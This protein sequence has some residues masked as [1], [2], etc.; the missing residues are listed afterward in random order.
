MKNIITLV[1]F[2]LFFT[3]TLTAQQLVPQ[4]CATCAYGYQKL[5]T[6]HLVGADRNYYGS[7]RTSTT[8]GFSAT[9]Q[10]NDATLLL[11][12]VFPAIGTKGNGLF[13]N[14]SPNGVAHLTEL[15]GNTEVFL[16]DGKV[17]AVICGNLLEDAT[18]ASTNSN[19]S[20]TQPSPAVFCPPKPCDCETL[21]GEWQHGPETGP[22][23]WKLRKTGM[24][25]KVSC[26]YV[27]SWTFYIKYDG[28]LLY[29]WTRTYWNGETETGQMHAQPWFVSDIRYIT[30]HTPNY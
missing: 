10:T 28:S 11:G 4:P 27:T 3:A 15:Q 20:T 13:F 23:A 6:R 22:C 14:Y 16:R 7:M 12:N 21:V 18:T 9:K 2:F 19:K 29:Q 1:V 17:Y 8:A 25:P 5:G 24:E 26:D 30:T